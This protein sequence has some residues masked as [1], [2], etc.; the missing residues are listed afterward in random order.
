MCDRLATELV[1]KFEQLE[2]VENDGNNEQTTKVDLKKQ[3]TQ[4]NESLN[5]SKINDKFTFFDSKYKISTNEVEK[6]IYDLRLD[7]DYHFFYFYFWYKTTI[8]WRPI[9]LYGFFLMKFH[10]LV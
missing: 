4:L 8:H 6:L 2:M 9:P 3:S 10:G 5:L 1:T 7:S